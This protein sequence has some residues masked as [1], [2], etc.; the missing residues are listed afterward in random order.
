MHAD[1]A[2]LVGSLLLLRIGGAEGHVAAQVDVLG[3]PL[4][5]HRSTGTLSAS[6]QSAMQTT[7]SPPHLL[8]MRFTDSASPSRTAPHHRG[9][10]RI[11][12]RRDEHPITPTRMGP[13]GAV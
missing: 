2:A 10:R 5:N 11:P 7:Y 1:W 6:S 4:A 13:D 9:H 8:H 3:G 12:C